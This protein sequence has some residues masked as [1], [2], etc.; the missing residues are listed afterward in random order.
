MNTGKVPSGS[1]N[2]RRKNERLIWG[3]ACNPAVGM[4]VV[5][6]FKSRRRLEAENLFLR[7]S[8]QRRLEAPPRFCL[9]GGDR[10]QTMDV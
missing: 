10:V 3:D 9:R 6:L 4:F 2:T 1:A 7:S 8:T 5:D